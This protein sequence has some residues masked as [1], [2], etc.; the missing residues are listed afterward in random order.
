MLKW[1]PS[2]LVLLIP[3]DT[4]AEVWKAWFL[5]LIPFF[6]ALG[7][8]E[9]HEEVACQIVLMNATEVHDVVALTVDGMNELWE[10]LQCLLEFCQLL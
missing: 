4:D 5:L 9:L 7:E 8:Q 2:I 6:L 3:Q 10:L 1:C